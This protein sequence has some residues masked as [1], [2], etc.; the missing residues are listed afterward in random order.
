ML[1]VGSKFMTIK[2]TA[3]ATLNSTWL[4]FFVM[5]LGQC[6]TITRK[7]HSFVVLRLLFKKDT[8]VGMG[9]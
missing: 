2:N 7:N 6:T 1:T 3:D 8:D 9:T 4:H 5:E